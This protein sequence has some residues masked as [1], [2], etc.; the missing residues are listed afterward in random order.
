MQHALKNCPEKVLRD[1]LDAMNTDSFSMSE[2][3]WDFAKNYFA[4]L[5]FVPGKKVNAARMR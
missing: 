3:C 1:M 4:D 2:F 5:L